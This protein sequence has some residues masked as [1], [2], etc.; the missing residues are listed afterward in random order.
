MADPEIELARPSTEDAMTGNTTDS[1]YDLQ[2]DLSADESERNSTGTGNDNP[3]QW[4]YLTFDTPLPRP[5]KLLAPH[6]PGNGP[7]E[8]PEL[9]QYESPFN[10]SPGRKRYI[11]WL[12]CVATAVTAYTAGSYTAA[13]SQMMEYW[14]VSKVAITVGVTTFT[15]GFAIAPMVLAPFSEINGRRPMFVVTGILYVI[16]QLCC[17]VTRSYPGYE[18]EQDLNSRSLDF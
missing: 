7:P 1:K 5:S 9:K 16:L 4:E 15:T 17:A 12:S 14:G 18:D 10:W 8:E 2:E 13:D 6:S 3:I 11:T